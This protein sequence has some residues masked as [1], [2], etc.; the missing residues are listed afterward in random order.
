V[1]KFKLDPTKPVLVPQAQIPIFRLQQAL[2][3]GVE[4]NLI[5]TTWGGLG[6][7]MCAEPTIR[8]AFK[9]FKDCDIS[10]ASETPR[11]FRHLPF[12]QVFDLRDETP[13]FDNYLRF[14]TIVDQSAQHLSVQFMSHMLINCVD[15]PSLHALR[16]QLPTAD[17]ELKLSSDFP[18]HLGNDI[19]D[20]IVGGVIVHPGKHWQT[21]TFPKKFWD[22]VLSGLLSHGITPI[23]IGANA[24]DNRG[25]VDVDTTDCIDLRNKTTI[26]EL[27]W[28]CQKAL[29]VLTNDS[30]P[31]HAA[32][33]GDAWIGYVATAKH[34][35]MITHW[36]HGQWQWR[37]KNFGKGGVWELVDFCPNKQQ[38]VSCEFVDPEVLQSWLPEPEEMTEW[39]AEKL[40]Q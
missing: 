9:N 6:D 8:Y 10:L 18:S 19:A 7:Q 20:K 35:D 15:Y 17:K 28:C 32:A 25:T 1:E 37:E 36:R 39:A 30:M 31:L 40:K 22:K 38:E 14:E 16:L 29:V 3:K 12:K 11:L 24:D 5:F 34:P 21:K 4:R 23:I 33:S 2:D 26:T 13:N 27:V